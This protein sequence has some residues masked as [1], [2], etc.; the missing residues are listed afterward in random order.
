MNKSVWITDGMA[1]TGEIE[2][3]WRKT[4]ESVIL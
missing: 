1:V 2:N 3:T 4:P